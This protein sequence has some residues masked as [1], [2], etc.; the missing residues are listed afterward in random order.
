[1]STPASAPCQTRT[2]YQAIP[3]DLRTWAQIAVEMADGPH[4]MSERDAR[5]KYKQDGRRVTWKV[6]GQRAELVS[7]SAFLEFHRDLHRGWLTV[8]H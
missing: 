8:R 3:S 1:V 7:L 2:H 5:R 4:P 6:P